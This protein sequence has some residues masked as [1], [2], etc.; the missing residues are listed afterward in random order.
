MRNTI[1]ALDDLCYHWPL[2]C[3]PSNTNLIVFCYTL[4]SLLS[5]ICSS[6][7]WNIATFYVKNVVG[8]SP[9]LKNPC[10]GDTFHHHHSF[11]GPRVDSNRGT[12]KWTMLFG[13]CTSSNPIAL[14]LMI[15]NSFLA[16]RLLNHHSNVD[17]A[18]VSPYFRCTFRSMS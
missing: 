6:L 4:I 5:S 18:T 7:P 15:D 2:Y 8:I 3:L 14:K 17:H 10:Y 1:L 16:Y 11:L 9:P 13:F 12:H